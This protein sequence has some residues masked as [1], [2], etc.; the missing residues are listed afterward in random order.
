LI[1]TALDEMRIL[2]EELRTQ[3]EELTSAREALE[4]ERQRY[5]NLYDFAPDAYVV[6]DAGGVI[7]DTNQAAC[8]L[9]N[10]SPSHL[11][12]KPLVVFVRERDR[13]TFHTRLAEVDVTGRL[14]GWELRIWPREQGPVDTEV[15]VAIAPGERDP[16]RVLWWLLR[17]VSERKRA[18]EE[19]RAAEA[20]F[21]DFLEAA[22]DAI[23]VIN[24]QG[25]I[26]L[27]NWQTEQLFG[28]TRDELIGQPPEILMPERFRERHEAHRSRYL[29]VPAT[30]PMGV[31]LELLA[32]RRDGTEFPVEISLSP[33]QTESDTLVTSIIRDVSD[34]HRLQADLQ[35]HAQALAEADRQKDAF[36]ATLGHEIRNPLE[37]LW[38]LLA[39][40]RAKLD[41]GEDLT[42]RL[43]GIERQVEQITRLADD[44]LDVSRIASGKALLRPERLDLAQLVRRVTED[45]RPRVVENGMSLDV[46]LPPEPVGVEGDAARLTQILAN[47]LQNA[48]KFTD[49]G[50]HLTVLV[51]PEPTGGR[52]RLTIQDTGVGIEAS[53]LPHIFERFRQ[54]DAS[55]EHSRGGLGLG[56]ALV[57]GL[58]E[59]HGGEV[60]AQSE[61]PG[62]GATFT[63]RLPMTE[64]PVQPNERPGPASGGDIQGRILIIEDSSLTVRALERLLQG[65]GLEVAVAY[66][67]GEGIA[68]AQALH[69]EVVISD[70]GLPDMGGLDVAR[71]LRKLP[72]FQTTRLIAV[73][74][75]AG[76][77]DRR[78]ALEA[79]FDLWLAKPVPP[80]MLREALTSLLPSR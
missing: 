18:A 13:A 59:L 22:P 74:G 69:P 43:A 7:L 71:A 46:R 57:K 51:G 76:E 56:L 19:A 35:Q 38:N 70:L 27:V 34:T 66:S 78:R 36:L 67:G 11:V 9:F 40:L 15:T 55:R 30:R 53:T 68:K 32:R 5:C 37:T 49:P 12:G 20:R 28:Y 62:R 39:L 4:A 6:T 80:E 63:I 21:R 14:S 31:G 17:D 45:F 61:G 60:T 33:L 2:E 44:L 52:A 47:L 72:D 24:S 50:G 8:T 77:E 26:E 10:I 48:A 75:Y 16:S 42:E 1:Q 65:W 3:N 23:V 58:V 79:G 25:R 54:A 29:A 41:G 73:S 64:A